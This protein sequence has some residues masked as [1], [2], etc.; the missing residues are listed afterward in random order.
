MAIVSMDDYKRLLELD[1][2]ESALMRG[3][4]RAKVR[5]VDITNK[6]RVLNLGR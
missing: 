6:A 1:R 4:R 3:R 2:A 5:V